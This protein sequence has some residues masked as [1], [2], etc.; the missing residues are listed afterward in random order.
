MTQKEQPLIEFVNVKKIYKVGESR[1]HAL[2]GVS[3]TLNRGEICCIIGTSGSGKSTLLNVAAGL[4]R[5]TSGEIIISGKHIEKYTESKLIAFR[6]KYV[7]FIFQSFNLM[8]QYTAVENVAL[9]LAF[10]GVEKQ[11]R[12][13]KA[14]E[15][16]KEVGLETHMK[17]KPTQLS[18]GQQQ[19]VGIA[20]ALV[21]NPDI[22]FADEMT[23]NLDSVTSKEVMELVCDIVR[24]HNKTLIMVTHDIAMADYA[25]KVIT[26]MDGK[27][28]DTVIKEEK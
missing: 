16:L 1:V 15:I 7:G 19:R 4:E 23:G 11:V 8:P 3:L 26:I 22:I 14:R 9:P 20:R 10:R 12:E 25:D 21:T 24:R 17:H 13:K 27:I 18:G 5:V 28:T 2:D 6:R